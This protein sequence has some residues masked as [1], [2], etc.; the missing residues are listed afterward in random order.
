MSSCVDLIQ[1]LNPSCEALNK[2]GGVNKRVWIGQMSQLDEAI[3]FVVDTNTGYV[4]ALGFISTSPAQKL[5]RFI[6][7]TYKNSGSYELQVGENANTY[8]HSVT[9]ALYHFTPEDRKTIETLAK[10]DDVF[11]I[12]ETEAQQVEIFGFNKGL[13]ASAGTGG[14][15]TNLNDSTAYT[16]TLSGQQLTMPKLMFITSFAATVDYLNDNSI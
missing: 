16:L 15:G 11:V 13:T 9:L 3:P 5:F 2:V 1:G 14:T 4:T 12:I 6:G 10:A 7:K 8:N